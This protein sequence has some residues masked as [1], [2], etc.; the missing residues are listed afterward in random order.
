MTRGFDHDGADRKLTAPWVSGCSG[1]VL[2][3]PVAWLHRLRA[4]PASAAASNGLGHHRSGRA[5]AVIVPL[6]AVQL[7]QVSGRGGP[8]MIEIR[9]VDRAL[10]S[11]AAT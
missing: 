5:V 9:L 3:S 1:T 8:R 11:A 7:D 6:A 10:W 4:R 2:D